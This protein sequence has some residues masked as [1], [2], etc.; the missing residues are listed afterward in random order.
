MGF[1]KPSLFGFD[2]LERD[3]SGRGGGGAHIEEH[4]I[5]GGLVEALDAEHA[6][7]EGDGGVVIDELQDFQVGKLTGLEEGV[8]FGLVEIAWDGQYSFLK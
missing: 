4:D 5:L 2:R 1:N 6:I 8:S 3:N 7:V